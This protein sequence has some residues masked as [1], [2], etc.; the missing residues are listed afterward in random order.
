MTNV[1]QAYY[2][3]LE[4]AR[5]GRPIP[6]DQSRPACRP[7]E[8]LDTSAHDPYGC[9]S[10][11]PPLRGM[12]VPPAEA[13]RHGVHSRDPA[14]LFGT[15]FD[16]RTTLPVPDMDTDGSVDAAMRLRIVATNRGTL[17]LCSH[18]AWVPTAGGNHESYARYEISPEAAERLAQAETDSDQAEYDDTTEEDHP[19]N[20]RESDELLW[21]AGFQALDAV[22]P[23]QAQWRQLYPGSYFDP[24][25]IDPHEAA[26]HHAYHA[27][28]IMSL[29]S[30]EV[31]VMCMLG[32]A[33]LS[34][35]EP[36]ELPKLYDWVRAQPEV[37]QQ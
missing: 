30:D 8:L 36:T 31:A 13:F 17:F 33:D 18:L 24:R 21:E 7:T 20:L 28:V 1:I 25:N 2:G 11:Q 5:R 37:T 4:I 12:V 9:Y 15:G 34:S 22:V 29:H 23:Y 27:Q 3:L 19:G 16:F 26:A 32:D 6:Y 10:E 14:T 35:V